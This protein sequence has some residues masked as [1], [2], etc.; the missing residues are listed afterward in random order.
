MH[1]GLSHNRLSFMGLG[2]TAEEA[3]DGEGRR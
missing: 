3:E 1:V 2:T